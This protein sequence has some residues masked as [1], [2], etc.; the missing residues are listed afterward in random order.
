MASTRISVIGAGAWGTALAHIIAKAGNNVTL[1]GRN[2]KII[3]ELRTS[4]TN[5]VYL[6]QLKLSN[7]I[8]PTENIDYACIADVILLAVPAQSVRRVATQMMEFTQPNSKIICCAKGFETHTGNLMSEVLSDIFHAD[9]LAFLSGPT[10]AAEIVQ[11]FPSAATLATS[12]IQ[13]GQQLAMELSSENFRLYFNTDIIGVQVGGA[14]KNIIAI[15]SG[16][17]RGQGFGENTRAA[18]VTRG[19]AETTRLA[20]KLG[21]VAQTL[22]GLAGL[23]D[24]LLSCSTTQSRNFLY[25][26]L[27][28]TGEKNDAILKKIGGVVEGVYSTAAIEKKAKLLEIELPICSAVNSILYREA[29]IASMIEELLQRPIRLE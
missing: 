6:N 7:R 27:L 16:I 26:N 9:Q 25:G 20:V 21:G 1:W 4:K 19:L 29:D 28:G 8:Y 23:G 15:A 17:A 22:A 2:K 12:D 18:L 13:V 5:S 3:E 10:F 24:L 11:G 14:A